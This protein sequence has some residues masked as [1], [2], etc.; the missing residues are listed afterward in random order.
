MAVASVGVGTHR[1]LTGSRTT[2]SAVG[3][4]FSN[5][6][7][8]V[9]EVRRTQAG[10]ALTHSRATALREALLR[11][12]RSTPSHQAVAAAASS[13]SATS[14]STSPAPATDSS[15][16]QT[17]AVRSVTTLCGVTMQ[18]SIGT[19]SEPEPPEVV[20]E[21]EAS[22]AAAAA[23]AQ[24]ADAKRVQEALLHGL[25]V[26]LL[27]S[28]KEVHRVRI[29]GCTTHGRGV[30]VGWLLTLFCAAGAR[31]AGERCCGSST[32]QATGVYQ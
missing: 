5:L 18:R 27:M 31:E 15:I 28:C 1:R 8:L 30:C 26:L 25:Y 2:A 6:A 21:R 7:S 9:A 22:Q 11:A 17:S 16:S 23:A 14:A 13:A 19:Q 3:R 24:E 4:L 20:A 12:T 10:T 32:V 29:V